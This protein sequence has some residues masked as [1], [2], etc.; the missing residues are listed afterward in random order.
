MLVVDASVLAVALLDD[1]P[2]GDQ[3]RARLRGEDLAAPSLIDLEVVSVWRGLARGGQLDARRV[4]FALE[5]LRALPL[6]RVDHGALV[7]RCWELRQNLT[8]Y[9]ASYVALAEA[10]Q[11]TLL[12]G[13]R[14]IARAPGPT[15][16]IEVVK[17]RSRPH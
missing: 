10:I 7:M 17:P 11:A 13:D 6:Q 14:R 1:G 8:V 2:D 15:C 3:L 16:L 5:D 4:A 12:T 9:D